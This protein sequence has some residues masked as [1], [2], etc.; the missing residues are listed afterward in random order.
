M[1]ELINK[2]LCDYDQICHENILN[3]NVKSIK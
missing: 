2:Y 1:N 3:K